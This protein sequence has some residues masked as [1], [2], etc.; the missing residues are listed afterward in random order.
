M[1]TTDARKLR[2]ERL[3]DL[4][5]RGVNTIHEGEHSSVIFS[6]YMKFREHL[7]H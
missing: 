2:S 7:K 5:K 4:R 6:F 3:T 1:K